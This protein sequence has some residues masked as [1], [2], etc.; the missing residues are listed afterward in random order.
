MKNLKEEKCSECSEFPFAVRLMK[1]IN[2]PKEKAKR[3][4]YR[5]KEVM[6]QWKEARKQLNTF[7]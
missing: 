6:E 4:S 2:D 3:E 7:H 1:L 5:Y